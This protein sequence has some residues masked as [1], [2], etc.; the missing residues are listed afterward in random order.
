MLWS[1]QGS[2]SEDILEFSPSTV[3]SEHQIQAIRL[4]REVFLP[5]KPSYRPHLTKIT[6]PFKTYYA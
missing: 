1:I 2:R 6:P 4:V 3:A 5:S